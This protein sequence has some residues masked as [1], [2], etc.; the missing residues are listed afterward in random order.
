M[1]YTLIIN[2]DINY[3]YAK[4]KKTEI[5]G[6]ND[7]KVFSLAQGIIVGKFSI[8]PH[9]G[10]MVID[11]F[12]F[13][14]TGWYGDTD[15]KYDLTFY[16]VVAKM[17]DKNQNP[18]TDGL[19]VKLNPVMITTARTEEGSFTYQ[20]PYLR[21]FVETNTPGNVVVIVEFKIYS[22]TFDHISLTT[23]TLK[24][25]TED[26]IDTKIQEEIK[27]GA[28]HN[29]ESFESLIMQSNYFYRRYFGYDTRS[30]LPN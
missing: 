20:F 11:P 2:I 10:R 7:T 21:S 15:I 4:D 6:I 13:T 8:I 26:D 29:I 17:D 27:K 28:F 18:Q 9:T 3:D 1:D 22:K 19:T 14:V 5:G 16:R 23:I 30:L 25:P 24:Q 12:T